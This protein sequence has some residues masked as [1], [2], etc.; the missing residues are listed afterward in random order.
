MHTL[1][2]IRGLPGSGKST[3]ALSLLN[4]TRDMRH[5]EADMFFMKDGI[6][7][8]DPT[9]LKDAHA[10][11]QGVVK[12]YMEFGIPVVVSNSFVKLWEMKPYLDMAQKHN[13]NVQVIE[14]N[15]N[16]GSTHDVPEATIERMRAAWEV[17][18]HG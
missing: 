6:Y 3:L 15:G 2:I 18:Y 4:T 9:Q 16:F 11:C 5:V 8:F 7:Q 1:Y 12:D 10:W 14:C 13:Y 17:Y